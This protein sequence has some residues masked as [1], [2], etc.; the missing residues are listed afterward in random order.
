MVKIIK[1]NEYLTCL[2]CM[3]TKTP[4]RILTEYDNGGGQEIQ[5]CTECISKF[6]KELNDE[7][8]DMD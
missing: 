4:Y 6:A 8:L 1:D 7:I 3:K 2:G 5:L